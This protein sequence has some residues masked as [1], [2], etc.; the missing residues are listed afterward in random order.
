MFPADVPASA[1]GEEA[2]LAAAVAASL[3]DA[4]HNPE[5][6]ELSER[7]MNA[8]HPS[9]DLGRCMIRY[10]CAAADKPLRA[11]LNV[12]GDAQPIHSDD[13]AMEVIFDDGPSPTRRPRLFFSDCATARE[14]ETRA[15]SSSGGI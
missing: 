15:P 6:E 14:D 2:A 9:I 3:K 10:G 1:A 8:D 13:Q 5:V 12:T 4:A 11:C 7:L